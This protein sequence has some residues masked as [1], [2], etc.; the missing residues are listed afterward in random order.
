MVCMCGRSIVIEGCAGVPGGESVQ[1]LV[2]SH[3]SSSLVV[4]FVTSSLVI[5]VG[6]QFGGWYGLPVPLMELVDVF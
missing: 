6:I 5:A 3:V 4:E 2:V 1:L